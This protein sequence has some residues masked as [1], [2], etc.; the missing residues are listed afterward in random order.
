[1]SLDKYITDLLN[2]HFPT[3][4]FDEIKA[5]FFEKGFI[6]KHFQLLENDDII[7]IYYKKYTQLWTKW[8]RQAR[9]IILMRTKI[10]NKI[11]WK[12]IKSTFPRSAEVITSFHNK[13]GIQDTENMTLTNIGMFAKSQQK[14]ITSLLSD[15][16][17]LDGYLSMKVDGM[18]LC[19]TLYKGQLANMISSQIKAN[20]DEFSLAVLS[21]VEELDLDF[22]PI[23][24]TQKTFNVSDPTTVKYIVTAI[25]LE[26][27]INLTEELTPTQAFQKYGIIFLKKLTI[28][29]E[30]VTSYDNYITLIFEAVCPNRTTF[31]GDTHHELAT[32]YDTGFMKVLAY[33]TFL[34]DNVI[35][36]PHYEFSDIIYQMGFDEPFYWKVDS[37]R[38]INDMLR[39][40]SDY[41]MNKMTMEQYLGKYNPSNT[42]PVKH[43]YLDQEGF[44]LVTQNNEIDYHKIKSKEYYNSHNPKDVEELINIAKNTNCFPNATEVHRFFVELGDN[45]KNIRLEIRN[46]LAHLDQK[47]NITND[48]KSNPKIMQAFPKFPVYRQILMLLNQSPNFVDIYYNIFCDYF[49]D[50]K[51]MNDITGLTG[52]TVCDKII[53]DLV[54]VIEPKNEKFEVTE[55]HVSKEVSAFY[56]FIQKIRSQNK[57]TRYAEFDS[58][59]VFGCPE[60]TDLDV[61]VIVKKEQDINLPVNETEL[62]KLLQS[63]KELD[64]ATICI[65]NKI[66]TNTGKGGKEIQNII[67]YTYD[68]HKQI[69]PN[70]VNGPIEVNMIEK[71]LATS[72][73]IL[74]NLKILIGEKEYA[75]ERENK[76]LAY[77]GQWSRVDFVLS[78]LGKINYDNTP[79]YK[80]IMKS[81]VMKII[82][83]ILLER[84][85]YEYTKRGLAEKFNN[86]FPN[87]LDNALWFLFRGK[88]GTYSK[89][90]QQLLFNEFERIAM[91]ISRENLI[92]HKLDLDINNNPT[93]L[94]NELYHEF[95]KSPFECNDAFEIGF[96][97]FSPDKSIGK[98]FLLECMNV[99]KLPTDLAKNYIAIAQRSEE[100]IKLFPKYTMGNGQGATQYDGNRWVSFYYNLIRGCITEMMVIHNANFTSIFSSKYDKVTVGFLAD[101]LENP[102]FAVAPD[103]LLVLYENE[104]VIDIIPVE[105]KC[106]T[107][108]PTDNADFRRAIKL[109]STQLQTSVKILNRGNKGIIA[110]IYIYNETINGESVPVFDVQATMISF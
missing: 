5:W 45:L 65:K 73:F 34:N 31:W 20:G 77:K 7:I 108:K 75:V 54:N 21:L 70:P 99:N 16:A 81:L 100:W 9:G 12:P 107:M 33:S 91:T 74:D 38:Q 17:L 94:P 40:L 102:T 101:N 96:T 52:R 49:P 71:I 69:Y 11:T 43:K 84:K 29:N 53:K 83:L 36:I 1:M 35:T 80:N 93:I 109:A 64:I 68:L 10:N 39:D 51:N 8:A 103:L 44:M 97:H 58:F 82:Q 27:G 4:P 41:I 106:L 76:I 26:C 32:S 67:H 25:L 88:E 56:M 95:L 6:V 30:K 86:I 85:E 3:S 59:I 105:I 92:W 48:L 110:I 28:F 50:L 78:V 90:C 87:N 62:R 57:V 60:S 98:H 22:L 72:K 23:I 15:D 104:I 42:F 46:I 63:D 79:G 89:E 47:E 61:A 24:S 55:I 37:S 66:V 2:K 19:V 13:N 18:M 14:V